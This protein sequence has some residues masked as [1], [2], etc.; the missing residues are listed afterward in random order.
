MVLT[1]FLHIG[2]QMKSISSTLKIA[3]LFFW[4]SIIWWMD[5]FL[6]FCVS[7]SCNVLRTFSYFNIYCLTFFFLWGKMHSYKIYHWPGAFKFTATLNRK[8]PCNFSVFLLWELRNPF[9]W[10]LSEI[11]LWENFPCVSVSSAEQSAFKTGFQ[12][13]MSLNPAICCPFETVYSYCF[14]LML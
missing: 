5:R 2:T 12:V 4:F 1:Y 3:S 10:C 8:S 6:P 14:S 13:V 9:S 11:W 7:L